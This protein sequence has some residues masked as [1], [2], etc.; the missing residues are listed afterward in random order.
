VSLPASDSALS[1]QHSASVQL[2]REEA[3]LLLPPEKR[4]R[5][6]GAKRHARVQGMS[7][8]DPIKRIIAPFLIHGICRDEAE[9]LHMLA[10]D[11][12][13]RQVRRYAERAEHFRALYQ[14]SMEHFAQQVAGLCQGGKLIPALSRLDRHEQIMQAEDDL[15]EWQAAEQFLMRWRAVEADLQNASAA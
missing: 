10:K 4:K 8:R 14:T 2:T 7:E 13:Q 9:V 1:P 12:V 3:G 11:Y 6:Q 15:E 5:L